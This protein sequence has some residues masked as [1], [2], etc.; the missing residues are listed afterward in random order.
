MKKQK[1]DILFL[2]QFFYPEYNSSSTLPS[3]TAMY[4][5]N[6]G[7]TVDALC[8]YPKEY[9]AEKNTPLTETVENVKIKRIKYVQLNRV[10]T[11]GRLINYFSFTFGAWLRRGYLKNYKCVFVYSN[12]PIL[13]YVPIIANK[14]YGTEFVFVAFDVYP[15]VAYASHT[16]TP[17]SIISKVMNRINHKIYSSAARV[18]S[19]TDEMKSFL[20]KNRPEIS[21]DRI[22][23]IANW[24]HEKKSEPT[25]DAYTY[26][27]Y[28][29]GQFIVA[30]FGNLGTCQDIETMMKAAEMLKDDDRVKFLIIGHGNKKPGVKTAIKEKGL[31]NVQLM[32]FIT[33]DRFQQAVSISSC[34]IVSLEKGLKGTCAPSKYYSYLQG[35][36]PVLAVVEPESYL[37]K[38]V[39]EER[40]GRYVETGDCEGLRNAISEMAE[41]PEMC[42]Q[43]GERAQKL[44]EEKYSY[45]TAMKKFEDMV[46]S[47]ID[48]EE[49]AK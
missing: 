15:E 46:K 17:D 2:C 16:L 45:E 19:L 42:R 27:G 29:E 18:V 44:Y 48:V 23:T 28:K 37:A 24:A 10:G 7:F 13:P 4:L 31:S 8:G 32:D 30:Y 40:I 3:D 20:A 36:H 49:T 14:K 5:A 38:E 1:R 26:F 35:G 25:K 22:V 11:L 6:H 9:T 43:M 41:N 47:I 33:D 21:A 34:C 12:P 39:E